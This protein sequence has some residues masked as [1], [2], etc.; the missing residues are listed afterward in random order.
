MSEEIL[1]R[2]TNSKLKTFDL[3]EIY[4]EGERVVFVI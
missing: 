4:P 1:N 3:E 2:V